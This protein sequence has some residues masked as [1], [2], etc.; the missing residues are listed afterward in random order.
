[1][2]SHGTRLGPALREY[3]EARGILAKDLAVA[4]EVS[5]SYISEVETDKRNLTKSLARRVAPE[6]A[7]EFEEFWEELQKIAELPPPDPP[8]VIR[9]REAIYK[10]GRPS[11][12]RGKLTDSEQLAVHFLQPLSKKEAFEL[13]RKF[14]D[15]AAAGD[16]K[17]YALA[18]ALLDLL[19]ITHPD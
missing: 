18:R 10:S 13:L 6:F 3:R 4:A 17:G 15:Q 2:A 7:M 19:P 16:S 9:D 11:D 12:R 1:M 14:T 5:P 8:Q